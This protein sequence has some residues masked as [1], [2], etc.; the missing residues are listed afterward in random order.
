MQVQI[1]KR[2]YTPEEYCRLEETAEYKNEYL[3]GEITPMVG[4]TTNH[5][6][7][8][9]NFCRNF[10]ANINNQDYWVLMSDVRLWMPSYR[11]YTYPDV[12]V[13]KDKPLYEGKGTNTVT[14][15]LIIVEVLS[16][17]TRDYDRTDKFKFYRSI[18]EFKEYILIDQYRYYVEQF[19]QHNNGEWLFKASESDKDALRFYSVDFQMSLLDIYQRIDFNL[20]EE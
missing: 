20:S 9:L 2:Y 19:Y 16:K 4:A 18:P 17:S 12:M 8:A 5:N 15:A 3:D 13:I 1:E 14:N 7:I 10:P 11:F 6:L